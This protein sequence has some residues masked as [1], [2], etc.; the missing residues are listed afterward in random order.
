MANPSVSRKRNVGAAFPDDFLSKVNTA[1]PSDESYLHRGVPSSLTVTCQF[2]KWV[3]APQVLYWY[4]LRQSNLEQFLSSDSY[5]W[6]FLGSQRKPFRRPCSPG[7]EMQSLVH[8]RL[9]DATHKPIS[10]SSS[11]KTRGTWLI[12]LVWCIAHMQ[13]FD[14][15]MLTKVSSQ[16]LRCTWLYQVVLYFPQWWSWWS[17][18][19]TLRALCF[20]MIGCWCRIYFFGGSCQNCSLLRANR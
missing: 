8:P 17:T 13:L 15:W 2:G 10:V 6:S 19:E 9:L 5:N 12:F 14:V 16:F 4:V 7:L 11:N 3:F 20:V 1:I 18:T